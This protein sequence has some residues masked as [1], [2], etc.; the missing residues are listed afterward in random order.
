MERLLSSFTMR[1]RF[2][3]IPKLLDFPFTGNY[4]IEAPNPFDFFIVDKEPT[5]GWTRPAISVEKIDALLEQGLLHDKNAR[6]WAI[7]TLGQLHFLDLLTKKQTK[8]FAN[9]LWDKLDDT[10]LPD[11]TYNQ[12]YY[13]KFEFIDLPHPDDVNPLSLFRDYVCGV[14]L[15]DKT[16]YED[17]VEAREHLEWS[18]EEIKSIFRRIVECWD[19]EKSSLN[20]EDSM[21]VRFGSMGARA[22]P[23]FK[24]LIGVLVFVVAPNFNLDPTNKDRDELLRLIGEFSDYDFPTIR[25]KTACLRIYPDSW[26]QILD[27][28]ENG[29]ASSSDGTVIDSLGAVLTFIT[30]YFDDKRNSQ[31]LPHLIG[32]LGQMIFWRSKTVLPSTIRAIKEIIY[33]RPSL[34]S[35]RFER[36]ILMGLENIADDTTGDIKNRNYLETLL[37]RKRA[38]CLAYRF[39]KFYADREKNCSQYNR[40]VASY[41]PVRRRIF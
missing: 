12:R 31:T 13:G 34:I 29:L 8:R 28:I 33:V 27:G 17:I 15:S 9:V 32:L 38:A 21:S 37:T 2:D 30:D 35:G 18:D 24:E 23:K 20:S 6:Q 10:G 14:S 11:Q 16:V 3:L 4:E 26:D 36:S 7:L 41:L 5:T 1:Q 25:L 40:K 19:S 22:R 39:F